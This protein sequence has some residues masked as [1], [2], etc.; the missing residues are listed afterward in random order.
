[1]SS[2]PTKPPA[3]LD[4]VRSGRFRINGGSLRVGTRTYALADVVSYRV[5]SDERASF[6][7]TICAFVVFMGLATFI[8]DMIVG[9]I[10]PFRAMIGVATLGFVGLASIQDI[11]RERGSG[12]YR[13]YLTFAAGPGQGARDVLVFATSVRPEIESVGQHLATV[14]PAATSGPATANGARSRLGDWIAHLRSR[15]PAA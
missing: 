7:G 14:L 9:Q 3:G 12:F 4:P 1:M 11:F 8:L 5:D 13:L 2:R 6:L 15:D 10:F